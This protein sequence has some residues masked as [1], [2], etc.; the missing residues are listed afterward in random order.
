MTIMMMAV[1]I[2][3]IG[4]GCD[5]NMVVGGYGADHYNKAVILE[6]VVGVVVVGSV[7]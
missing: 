1:S 6:V 3:V 5:S 7:L 2:V 4:G